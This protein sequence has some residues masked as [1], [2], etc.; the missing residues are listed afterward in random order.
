MDE[1]PKRITAILD[2]GHHIDPSY[3]T[4]RHDIDQ[5]KAN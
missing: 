1:S 2:A 5:S 3:R 4:V